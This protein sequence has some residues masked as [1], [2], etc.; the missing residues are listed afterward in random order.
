MFHL[1]LLV[2]VMILDKSYFWK[3]STEDDTGIEKIN[4]VGRQL[5]WVGVYRHDLSDECSN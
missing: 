5:G 3:I 1:L 2:H 4:Y